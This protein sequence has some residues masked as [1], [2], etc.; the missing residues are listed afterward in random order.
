MALKVLKQQAETPVQGDRLFP[1]GLFKF[2]ILTPTN[3]R[4]RPTPE[5]MHNAEATAAAN[6]ALPENKQR[7][8]RVAGDTGDILSIWL[9]NAEAL[10][11]GQDSPGKQIFFQDLLI[12]DGDIRIEDLDPESPGAAG[13]Q[14]QRDARLAANLAIALGATTEVTQGGETYVEIA[15]NFFEMLAAGEFDGQ[16]VVAEVKHTPWKNKQSG[17]SGTNVDIAQFTP[18][19]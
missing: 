12:R 10:R 18:A 16:K 15:E 13:W 2:E 4:I 14:I 7:S 17:K 1:A 9:G 8:P 11:E 19:V 5:F 6:A 3:Q